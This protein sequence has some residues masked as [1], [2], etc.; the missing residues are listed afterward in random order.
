MNGSSDKLRTVANYTHVGITFAVTIV[1]FFFGGYW[2]DGKLDTKPILSII[3]AFLGA[4]G[5]FYN[6]V[7]SL[8]KDLKDNELN[9]E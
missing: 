9:N 3:G 1:A 6:L 2:L 4:G 7:R 8:N 5:G